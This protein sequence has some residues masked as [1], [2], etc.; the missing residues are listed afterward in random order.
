MHPP[1]NGHEP[2]SNMYF[3]YTYN[4]IYYPLEVHVHDDIINQL[5]LRS[6]GFNWF[7]SGQAYAYVMTKSILGIESISARS[8]E[9]YS[10]FEC[11]GAITFLM[12]EL[13]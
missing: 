7:R 11:T 10:H 1:Q 8:G 13:P 4:V 5:V 12:R 2:L 6:N 9:N 3:I